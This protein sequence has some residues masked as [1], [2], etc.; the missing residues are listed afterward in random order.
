[1]Q[2]CLDYAVASVMTMEIAL[3]PRQTLPANRQQ[4][5]SREICLHSVEVTQRPAASPWRAS[6]TLAKVRHLRAR[7]AW[8]RAIRKYV[9]H[10]AYV[11]TCRYMLRHISMLRHV[12]SQQSTLVLRS[13]ACAQAS[14][15]SSRK[16]WLVYRIWMKAWKY[17]ET[18]WNIF[19]FCSLVNVKQAKAW[20]FQGT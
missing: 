17:L 15:W 18:S 16:L 9:K 13:F 5:G 7:L 4:N 8:R 14:G 20:R 6:A 1:M 10:S 3:A 11:T 2:P 19:L 12:I